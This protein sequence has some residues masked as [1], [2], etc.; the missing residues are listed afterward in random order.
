MRRKRAS[1]RQGGQGGW[2][3]VDSSPEFRW[4]RMRALAS[5]GLSARAIAS[6][7]KLDFGDVLSEDQVRY[8]LQEDRMPRI[9]EAQAA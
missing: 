8:A 7:I 1:E 9:W 5:A 6:V 3:R 4:A 2:F